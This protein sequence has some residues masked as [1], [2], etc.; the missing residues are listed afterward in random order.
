MEVGNLH[1]FRVGFAIVR[2]IDPSCDGLLKAFRY[3]YGS[4]D[5]SCLRNLAN[6]PIYWILVQLDI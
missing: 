2:S 5:I 4:V 6:P 3:S 1:R